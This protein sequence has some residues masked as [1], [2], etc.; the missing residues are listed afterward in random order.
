V[1]RQQEDRVLS[2]V[3]RRI[4]ESRIARGWTQEQFAERLDVGAK[5]IQAVERGLEN[6]TLRTL[7]KIASELGVS[8]AS[9]LRRP[10]SGSPRRGRPQKLVDTAPFREIIPGPGELYRRSVPL[11]TLEA[12]AGHADQAQLVETSAWVIPN[13]RRRLTAGMF[14]ARIIGDSMVPEIAAGAWGLFRATDSAPSGAVVLVQRR[15]PDDPE[16][17][18]AYQLKRVQGVARKRVRL[19]STNPRY[20][21]IVLGTDTAGYSITALLLEILARSG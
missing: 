18:G 15:D 3:G 14:V 7:A 21:D 9:L 20:D 17:A 5:Y 13:T 11:M 19:V 8:I 4:A 10:L 16:D 6:L 12:R 1:R 2:D